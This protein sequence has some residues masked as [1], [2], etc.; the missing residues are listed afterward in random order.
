MTG[1]LTVGAAP[2]SAA[3]GAI[4]PTSTASVMIS[5]SVAPRAWTSSSGTLC[6]AAPAAGYSLR[7]AGSTEP[8]AGGSSAGTCSAGGQAAAVPATLQASGETLLIVA[9]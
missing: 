8:L 1:L 2:A 9:E 6:I 3:D 7:L 4:G 5:V